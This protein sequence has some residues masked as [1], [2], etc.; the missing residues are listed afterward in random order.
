MRGD[1]FDVMHD[2]DQSIVDIPVLPAW[3]KDI[4][5]HVDEKG[6][7]YLR[8]LP[9]HTAEAYT[10]FNRA[11]S[12]CAVSTC[13]IA[14]RFETGNMH[15]G[16]SLEDALSWYEYAA[17]LGSA[18]AALRLAQ[19]QV[20]VKGKGKGAGRE[21]AF[22]AI[23]ILLDEKRLGKDKL[24]V[25][26]KAAMLLLGTTLNAKE[27]EAIDALLGL[28]DFAE[29]PDYAWISD[30]KRF[31][32]CQTGQDH[33]SLAVTSAKITEEGDFR[34]GIYK[35]LEKPLPLVPVP[36]NPEA[37]RDTLDREFP[38][39]A[40]FNALIYRQLVAAQFS[41]KPAF[42]VRPMLLAGM[43]GVGKTT[44][45]KRLAELC[46]VPFRS[47][48]AAGGADGMFLRGTPRGWSSAR[49][50][51]V[52]QTMVTEKV[53]NPLFMVDELEKAS[54]DNRNGR[55]WD[56]LLQLLE[57]ASSKS[58]L[59]ECLQVPCDLSWVS[60]IA[61]ANELGDIPSPLL[62]RF[63]VVKAEGPGEDHFMT[64][65]DGAVQRYAKE[66]GIDRRMLPVLDIED[67]EVLRQCKNPREVSRTVM[68]MLE[69]GLVHSR[70]SPKS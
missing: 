31:L 69:A 8:T 51:A 22:R 60:W 30:R 64:M 35:Q 49:P 43:P 34:P 9:I 53:A 27:T 14:D 67:L 29:H 39:F 19:L 1:H 18:P 11:R 36:V 50:G 12:G 52:L 46:G 13:E 63:T 70:Q 25:A 62:E 68:L 17:N 10:L 54:P 32:A 59:D 23:E 56:V 42:R 6:S 41:A 57:P 55:L 4:D 15:G 24:M 7:G 33:L 45:V 44:W 47:V 61:T 38:W 37:I 48:M 40:S 21:M 16:P 20:W 3:V 2:D 58:Y 65:V 28:D 66:I 26:A 5:L